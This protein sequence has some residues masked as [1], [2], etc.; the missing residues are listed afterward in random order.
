MAV[1]STPTYKASG[2]VHME[3]GSFTSDGGIATVVLGYLPQRFEVVNSTD[4]ILWEKNAGMAAANCVKQVAAG[5][6]TIDTG[7]AILFNS[8]GT[9]TVS[10]TLCGTSKAISWVAEG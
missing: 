10:T 2:V 5:T 3:N 9:V 6:T 8:D 1:T 7:S 4:T